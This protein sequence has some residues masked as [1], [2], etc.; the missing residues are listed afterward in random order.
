MGI[1]LTSE[2]VDALFDCGEK[3]LKNRDRAAFLYLRERMDSATSTTTMGWKSLSLALEEMPVQGSTEKPFK[4]T[5]ETIRWILRR[6]EEKGLIEQ[7][8]SGKMVESVFRFP[9]YCWT[10]AP[11]KRGTIEEPRSRDQENN[12]ESLIKINELDDKKN[13]KSNQDKIGKRNHNPIHPKIEENTPLPTLSKMSEISGEGSR[14]RGR[15]PVYPEA[16][17]QAVTAY[18]AR[19][20][21]LDK[22]AAYRAWGARKNEGYSSEEILAGIERYKRFVA[23]EGNLGTK[24]VKMMSTFLGKADPPFFLMPWKIDGQ[25]GITRGTDRNYDQVDYQ[26]GATPVDRIDWMGK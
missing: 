10:G 22:A 9:L 25:M 23:A 8:D 26:A 16:F 18:P 14:G 4:G 12:Q 19:H 15:V 1:F 20:T 5:R 24:F 6:L 3:R 21:A 7:L 13:R 11:E 2:E 17:L